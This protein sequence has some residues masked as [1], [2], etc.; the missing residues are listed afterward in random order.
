[1]GRHEQLGT[2]GLGLLQGVRSGQEEPRGWNEAVQRSL[3]SAA[4]SVG[5]PR[6]LTVTVS[7]RRRSIS[8][9]RRRSGW[10]SLERSGVPSCSFWLLPN[11]TPPQESAEIPKRSRPR[12][13]PPV[14][15]VISHGNTSGV[16]VC[17]FWTEMSG[18]YFET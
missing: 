13:Q 11:G 9:G 1:M 4:I 6:T 17:C 5:G 2:P 15:A 7:P 3:A 14:Q 8:Q 16:F 12:A 18:F 10:S